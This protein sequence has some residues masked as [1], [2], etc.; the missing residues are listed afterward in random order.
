M[1]VD[2]IEI[3]FSSTLTHA[4]HALKCATQRSSKNFAPVVLLCHSKEFLDDLYS[5]L[6]SIITADGHEV[7]LFH[8][9]AW[10]HAPFS[11]VA[12]SI[13]QKIER[14]K[15]LEALKLKRSPTL[16]LASVDSWIQ[17][18]LPRHTY[19][20]LHAEIKIQ[21][22]VGSRESL[23]EILR[24]L[25]YTQSE[26]VEEPGQYAI[27][28]EILDLYIPTQTTP[29]RIEFFDTQIETIRPF[30][31]RNPTHLE[32]RERYRETFDHP[33]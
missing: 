19:E 31:S 1:A 15:T 22:D 14:L 11:P 20:S 12:S 4:F 8:W 25:G 30:S 27:R 5:C 6:Q 21:S 18:T 16:I 32:N 17:P 3:K 7:A 2:Q 23:R 33:R 10:E 28:G 9:Q 26:T 13:T 29:Y 24:G